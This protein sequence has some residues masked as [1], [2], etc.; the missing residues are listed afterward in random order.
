MIQACMMLVLAVALFGIR[1][2]GDIPVYLLS[3]GIFV[4]C[5]V[6]F[7]LLVGA[8]AQT[9]SAAVQMVA[10][11]GFTTALLL[12]GFIYPVR[13]IMFPLSLISYVVPARYFVDASRNA[14][15]RGSDALSQIQIPLYLLICAFV[16]YM[17][18]SRILRKMQLDR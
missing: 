5:S 18:A 2:V 3:L 1:L 11:A 10:T 14:F 15:V 17:A 6:L 9:Q 12:S 7:G 4:L 16:F 8:R 13:N